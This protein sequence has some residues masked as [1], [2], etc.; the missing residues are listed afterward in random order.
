MPP[1][2]YDVVISLV[3]VVLGATTLVRMGTFSKR[4]YTPTLS[5]LIVCSGLIAWSIITLVS[6]SAVTGHPTIF[7]S[8]GWQGGWGYTMS[9]FF[10]AVMWSLTLLQILYYSPRCRKAVVDEAKL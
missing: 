4:K 7:Y 3:C 9:R 2:N 5:A 10:M 6:I 8:E 1:I